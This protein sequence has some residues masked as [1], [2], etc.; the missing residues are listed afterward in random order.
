MSQDVQKD[1]SPVAAIFQK[2]HA[3]MM[4]LAR[5]EEQFASLAA[6]R[7]KLQEELRSL[8]SEINSELDRAVD[9]SSSSSDSGSSMRMKVAAA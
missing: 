8:Q 2:T 1:Q 7:S 5:I 9:G 4:T 3:K 6:Q